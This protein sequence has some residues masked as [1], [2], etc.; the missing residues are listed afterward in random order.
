[1]NMESTSFEMQH[2]QT[3]SA[4]GSE[5]PLFFRDKILAVETLSA[6][7]RAA[8]LDW[9]QRRLLKEN[10]TRTAALALC[11][12]ALG[13][14][15]DMEMALDM[16]QSFGEH[17]WHATDAHELRL[18]GKR[19]DRLVVEATEGKAGASSLDTRSAFLLREVT[20]A[21]DRRVRVEAAEWHNFAM[22]EEGGMEEG[23]T[24]EA[25]VTRAFVL[26]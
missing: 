10:S 24:V 23:V 15:R 12:E 26:H 1:M 9:K 4:G 25:E 14:V 5:A 6:W 16:L 13:A 8:T 7:V 11:N 20:G 17:A 21:E 2:K 18:A 3:G 19:I 22:F